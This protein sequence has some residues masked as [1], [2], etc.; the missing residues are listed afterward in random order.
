MARGVWVATVKPYKL[1]GWL[2]AIDG[3]LLAMEI[4]CKST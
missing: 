4:K 2:A 1:F 3:A